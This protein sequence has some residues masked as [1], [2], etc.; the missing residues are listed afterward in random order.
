MSSSATK[1][2]TSFDIFKAE[3]TRII[4]LASKAKYLILGSNRN[5]A[6]IT[7]PNFLNLSPA[8]VKNEIKALWRLW[9]PDKVFGKCRQFLTAS[10]QDKINGVATEVSTVLSVVLNSEVDLVNKYIRARG[11]DDI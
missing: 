8:Y 7:C 6:V 5:E 3:A 9:H 10:N 2:F 1:E 4:K 11:P